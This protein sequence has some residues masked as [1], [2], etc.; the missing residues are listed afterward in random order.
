MNDR[1][2]Q[3]DPL[4][5]A[6]DVFH[7]AYGGHRDALR[8]QVPVLVVLPTQLVLRQR[9]QRREIP[10]S[11]PLFTRAKTAAHVAVALF[12]L[13]GAGADSAETSSAVERLLGHISAFDTSNC[14]PRS[15]EIDALVERC[16]GFARAL[17]DGQATESTLADFASDAGAR[18]L[19]I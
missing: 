17:R 5:A 8:E 18:I 3:P 13:T 2:G 10:Y 7:D 4:S 11:Q 9:D 12:A 1:A 19:R 15:D 14:G 16:R 6:N